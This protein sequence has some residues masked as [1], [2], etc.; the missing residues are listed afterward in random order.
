MARMIKVHVLG[1]NGLETKEVSLEEAE[2]ILKETYADSLGGLVTDRRTGKVIEEIGP[3]VEEL[4][5]IN[6]IIGGG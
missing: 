5:I 1:R 4:L 3:D 2:R 6:Y